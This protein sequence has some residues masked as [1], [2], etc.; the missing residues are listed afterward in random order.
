MYGLGCKV[1][2][3]AR[4]NPEFKRLGYLKNVEGALAVG[5]HN[6]SVKA[7]LGSGLKIGRI[8][9][10]DGK[11]GHIAAVNVV[12]GEG[13]QTEQMVPKVQEFEQVSGNASSLK[14]I[15]F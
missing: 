12:A 13:V 10:H 3:L 5:F 1:C 14:H 6:H 7:S 4:G 15:R 8:A 9:L 2:A 11:P